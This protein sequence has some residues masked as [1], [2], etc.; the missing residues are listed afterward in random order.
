MAKIHNMR[1]PRSLVEPLLPFQNI[2]KIV[3]MVDQMIRKPPMS[4]EHLQ[5]CYKGTNIQHFKLDP[6]E[7]NP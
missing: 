6:H 3:I 1:K 5:L 4:K 7:M 2:Y